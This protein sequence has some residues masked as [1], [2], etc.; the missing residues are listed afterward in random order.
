MP[1]SAA[2]GKGRGTRAE[3]PVR[4]TARAAPAATPS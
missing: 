1:A 2:D 3:Q 4:R